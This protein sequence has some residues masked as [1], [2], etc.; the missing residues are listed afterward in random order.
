[1]LYSKYIFFETCF[2]NLFIHQLILEK[3]FRDIVRTMSLF[4]E[5][6]KKI[7]NCQLYN[8]NI[9]QNEENVE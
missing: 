8:L 7:A 3:L 9:R 2:L 6:F 1:M 5:S 4:Y